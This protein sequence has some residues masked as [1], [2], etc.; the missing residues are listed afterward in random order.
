[1][2]FFEKA[3]AD[4]R[5]AQNYCLSGP[6][7]VGKRTIAKWVAS[8][9]LVVPEDKL[10]QHP[11]F[12]YLERTVDLETGKLRKDFLIEQARDLKSRL[13]NRSWL[14]GY[15]VMIVDEAELLNK[16]SGNAL[17]KSLEEPPEKT[18]IF[19]L[20]ENEAA[21]LPTVRSRCQVISC[22]VVT[23][24]SLTKGLQASG[25][26]QTEI[27]SVVSLAWGRPGRAKYFLENPEALQ[28][29]QDEI[30]RWQKLQGK[31]FYEQIKLIEDAFGDP[32]DA[33]RGREKLADILDV[34]M[35]QSR[36]VLV[37]ENS[38][39]LV[40]TIDYLAEARQLLRQNVHPKLIMEQAVLRF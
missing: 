6:S 20:T 29:V 24:E 36:G 9:L 25:H 12:Y 31:A 35:M 1:M 30:A 28:N 39:S 32:D 13:Q 33:T 8:Q 23:D 38:P 10:A 14:G 16:A 26:S 15:Q 40:T 11:D 34:W 4:K 2:G 21:L 19:L 37:R 17:L 22:G 5:L 18:V 27:E 3:I 7:Q